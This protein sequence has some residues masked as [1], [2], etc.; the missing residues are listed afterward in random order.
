MF[1]ETVF[2][3]SAASCSSASLEARGDGLAV[4][5]VYAMSALHVPQQ[6]CCESG[7]QKAIGAIDRHPYWY[8][9]AQYHLCLEIDSG[10][11]QWFWD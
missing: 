1:H 2:V 9:E 4:A 3:S 6:N 5:E 7:C 11:R 10:V 8:D